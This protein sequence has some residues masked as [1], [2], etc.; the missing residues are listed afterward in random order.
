[1]PSIPQ[2]F[3]S[4]RE[5]ISDSSVGIA[6]GYGLDDRGS[7]VRYPAGAGNFLFTT[8][9]RTALGLTQPPIQW[10]PGALSLG[11][12]RP[13]RETDHS[14]PS[15]AEVKECVELYLHSPNMPSWRGAS[16]STGTTLPT[17]SLPL[18]VFMQDTRRFVP[19]LHEVNARRGSRI[20]H[21]PC[22]VSK[23]TERI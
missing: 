3:L 1:M 6:L 9:P 21:S 16:L 2:A 5:L 7:R 23:T 11:I 10:I 14:P 15:S 19:S 4:F 18:W 8:A 17:L 20:H 13:G 22:F 12:K